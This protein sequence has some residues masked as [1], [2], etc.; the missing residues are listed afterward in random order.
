MSKTY[1]QVPLNRTGMRKPRTRNE[2][3]QLRC[4]KA[5]ARYCDLDISPKNRLNR[6]IPTEFDDLHA[7]SVYEI[8]YAS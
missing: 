7:S 3:R 4:L 2:R 1:R 8:D 5:D 6:H